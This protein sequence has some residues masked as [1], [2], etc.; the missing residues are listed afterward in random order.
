M[1]SLPPHAL[2]VP[3]LST[4]SATSANIST[5]RRLTTSDRPAI[6]N[7]LLRLSDGDRQMRFCRA[8][9][10]DGIRAYAGLINVDRDIGIGIFDRQ[11][12]LVA[13]VQGF[14]YEQDGLSIMEAA[15]STDEAMRRRGLATLLFA[16]ITDHALATGV[17]RV[18]AQ[19]LAENRPMRT[20]LHAVGATCKVEDG[21]VIGHLRP[22]TKSDCCA[23]VASASS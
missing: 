14:A 11:A 20:L 2:A 16:E 17:D 5:P 23:N 13:L 6:L 9:N 8:V 18:L 7:H 12:S 19:C 4:H 1:L 22:T 3:A 21:E 15:F 10:D